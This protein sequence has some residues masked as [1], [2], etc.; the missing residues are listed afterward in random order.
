MHNT[1]QL[2]A[3]RQS[4][5]SAVSQSVQ[6]V[7]Q[8]R[9]SGRLYVLTD[10]RTFSTTS[11]F[12]SLVKWYKRG[13]IVG[14]ET[15]N[16]YGGDSGASVSYVLKN[17]GLVINIPMV[18]CYLPSARRTGADRAVQPDVSMSASVDDIV[19]GRDAVKAKALE[20][21]QHSQ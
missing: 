9:F 2:L 15:G 8:P 16:A 10:A 13:T 5:T 14:E 6:Q 18:M 20:L 17:S 19:A 12:A 11:E 3:V 21:I 1:G 4:R 7:R